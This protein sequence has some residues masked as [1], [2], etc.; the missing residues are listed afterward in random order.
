M[1]AAAAACFFVCIL[2]G[3]RRFAL[4]RSPA[5]AAG[6]RREL[7]LNF[8]EAPDFSPFRFYPAVFLIFPA[9]LLFCL[10]I[11]QT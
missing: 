10:G 1:R 4:R 6:G 8:K 2:R 3:A 9:F 5:A 11:I 7:A